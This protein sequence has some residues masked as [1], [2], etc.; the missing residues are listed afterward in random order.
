MRRGDV[1]WVRL[2]PVTGSEA[3]K[4][5]PAVIVS[6]DALNRT[7]ERLRRGVVTVAPVTGSVQQVH[8]FQVRLPAGTAGLA[9]D[10]KVQAEQVRTISVH[11]L[12]SRLGTLPAP[13]LAQLDAALRIHLSL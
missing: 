7:T 12:G 11:R 5:R 13:L 2:E 9:K 8:T 4:T 6:N 10:S 3:D 1:Y